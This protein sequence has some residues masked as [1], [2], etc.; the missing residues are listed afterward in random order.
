MRCEP[1]AAGKVAKQIT[2]SSTG[3]SAV[4]TRSRW[5]TKWQKRHGC[6]S[7]Q[8]RASPGHP[9]WRQ[10]ISRKYE[11]DGGTYGYGGTDNRG[12]K[13][14]DL[15]SRKREVGVKVKRR[16]EMKK[17][18]GKLRGMGYLLATEEVKWKAHDNNKK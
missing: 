9:G 12:C 5:Q 3:Q 6:P 1:N 7:S 17:R 16:R 13:M 15:R 2:L 10:K 8:R 11:R 14:R 4:P 18:K